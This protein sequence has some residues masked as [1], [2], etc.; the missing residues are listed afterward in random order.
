MC[1][2][3]VLDLDELAV[4]LAHT[5]GPRRAGALPRHR[6]TWWNT[7]RRGR[8]AP[9]R[10]AARSGARRAV[11]SLERPHLAR[12]RAR[13]R[14]GRA[15]ARR[16]GGVE[17]GSKDPDRRMCRASPPAPPHPPRR[18]AVVPPATHHLFSAGAAPQKSQSP[19][20][21]GFVESTLGKPEGTSASGKHPL[22]SAGSGGTGEW[23]STSS[24]GFCGGRKAT[25]TAAQTSASRSPPPL[26]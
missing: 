17:V 18:P 8:A 11:R 6:V 16:A 26:T 12:Q 24:S 13:G 23:R 1:I 20:A 7:A 10:G 2:H 14:Q 5:S 3:R 19:H 9:A 22:G 25:R 15:G 4:F 21:K